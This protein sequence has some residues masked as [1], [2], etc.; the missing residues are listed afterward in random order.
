MELVDRF[1]VNIVKYIRL[2][3]VVQLLPA[4]RLALLSQHFKY[5]R[6]HY[7]TSSEYVK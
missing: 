1:S 2:E 7:I 5:F 3:P 4:F 6:I